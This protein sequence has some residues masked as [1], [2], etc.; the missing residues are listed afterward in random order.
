MWNAYRKMNRLMDAMEYAGLAYAQDTVR[1]FLFDLKKRTTDR[2]LNPI[3]YALIGILEP[4]GCWM[5]HCEHYGGSSSFCGCGLGKVPGR[6]K[7]FR[8]FKE[9]QKARGIEVIDNI[10]HYSHP[11]PLAESSGELIATAALRVDGEV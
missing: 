4:P 9:R 8:E 1:H 5:S 6:C 3:M 10:V 2:E 11:H 7:T